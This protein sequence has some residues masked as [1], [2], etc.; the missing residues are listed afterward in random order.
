MISVTS[1]VLTSLTNINQFCRARKL[2]FLWREHSQSVTPP[3]FTRW[4]WW[5][6]TQPTV[7]APCTRRADKLQVTY[8]NADVILGRHNLVR[9]PP[10]TSFELSSEILVWWIFFPPCYGSD[11]MSRIFRPRRNRH[12]HEGAAWEER[13]HALG[14]SGNPCPTQLPERENPSTVFNDSCCIC[15][16]GRRS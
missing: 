2:S 12:C 9:P 5:R 13:C 3:R 8:V 10:W 4:M 15:V 11:V 16:F 7:L 14:S 1:G 6:H